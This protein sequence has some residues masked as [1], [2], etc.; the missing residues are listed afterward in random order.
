M[1]EGCSMSFENNF[2]P[3]SFIASLE[4]TGSH[5][6]IEVKPTFWSTFSYV[7]RKKNVTLVS[8]TTSPKIYTPITIKL[9]NKKF[10]SFKKKKIPKKW[11]ISAELKLQIYSTSLKHFSFL[12]AGCLQIYAK[13]REHVWYSS[14]QLDF[15]F[16]VFSLFA[17]ITSTYYS[18][19]KLSQQTKHCCS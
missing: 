12:I 11:E 1:S 5:H 6:W 16:I 3:Y 19:A 10:Y 4:T 14:I 15:F 9:N 2:S 17:L 18:T 13:Q 8:P 7:C